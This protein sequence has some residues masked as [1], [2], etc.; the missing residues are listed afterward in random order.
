[1]KPSWKI[2]LLSADQGGTNDL[3]PEP[4][5]YNLYFWQQSNHRKTFVSTTLFEARVTCSLSATIYIT[6]ALFCFD[7][8]DSSCERMYGL[9]TEEKQ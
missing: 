8:I 6:E 7:F 9:K 3:P 2:S 1:M 4:T 5:L